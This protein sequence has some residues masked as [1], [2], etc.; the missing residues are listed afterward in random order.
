[1]FKLNFMMKNLFLII[2][3]LF[4]LKSFSQVEFYF[5][6]GLGY[7]TLNILNGTTVNLNESS[8][9]VE[10]TLGCKTPL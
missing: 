5:D 9:F 2:F 3:L 6:N 1:M 10:L 4:G 7:D 8:S